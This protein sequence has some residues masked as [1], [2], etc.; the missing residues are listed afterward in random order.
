M[1][2]MDGPAVI[3]DCDG[4][5][6]DTESVVDRVAI[7]RLA[8]FGLH[9]TVEGFR[10]RFLGFGDDLFERALDADHQ[11]QFDAPL[12]PGAFTDMAAEIT[13]AILADVVPVEGA[14]ELALR[15]AGPAAVAS[16]SPR[17][18]LVG[19]LKSLG[20]TQRFGPHVFSGDDVATS[21]P[22]PDLFLAAARSLG[23]A[24]AHCR[25]IEDSPNGVRAAVAAGMPV[26]GFTGVAHEP[27]EHARRL[28]DAGAAAVCRDMREAAA[29]FAAQGVPLA[30][31]QRR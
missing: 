7:P 2:L 25:V 10:A 14:V 29:W 17:E 21:K 5:L 8:T 19:K 31:A 4:V 18:A 13:R 22:A 20:L 12:P 16:S 15:I 30:P 6:A 28:L 26:V 9:Y 1:V 23:V 27:L 24:P 11:A 3:F